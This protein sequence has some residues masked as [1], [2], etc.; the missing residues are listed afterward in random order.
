MQSIALDN[1]AEKAKFTE[2]EN[3]FGEKVGL[4][5]RLFGCWHDNLSRPFFQ[6]KT[7]YRSC[8]SCG[9]RK[10]FDPQS[11]KTDGAFYHPPIVK[12]IL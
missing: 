9:A 11:L 5:G 10:K 8:L 12:R 3:I 4:I 7:A 6:N 1:F 2:N